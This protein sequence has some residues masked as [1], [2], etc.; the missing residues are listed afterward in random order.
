MQSKG[1]ILQAFVV[2]SGTTLVSVSAHHMVDVWDTAKDPTVIL[3]DRIASGPPV[4]W[5][6]GTRDE[7]T[8]LALRLGPVPI[9]YAYTVT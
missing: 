1:Q 5:S 6:P 7:S 3:L 8:N 2:H 9:P 4:K